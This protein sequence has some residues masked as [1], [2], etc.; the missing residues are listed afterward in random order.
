VEQL[1]SSVRLPPRRSELSASLIGLPS[2]VPELLAAREKD[3]KNDF[4]IGRELRLSFGEAD[5]QSAALSGR[6][7]ASGIGKGTRVGLLFPNDSAWVVAWLAVARVGALAVP[8]STFSPAP[9]LATAIRHADVHAVL[10]AARFGH[11][12]LIARLEEGAAGLANSP[13]RLALP[14]LPLLRWIHVHDDSPPHWSCALA[15]PLGDELVRGAQQT[16]VAPD[17]LVIVSTSGATAAPK[18]VVHT[19]GSLVRHGALL[20]RHRGL[21][22]EDRI[23]SPMPFFWVG[24]LTMV[25]LAAL[26]SGAAA[27][28]QE[29]FDAG[30]ALLLAERE[31]VTQISCWPNAARSMA[32]HPTFA[33]RDLSS[34]RGGTLVEAL[35]VGQ[36]PPSPDR[37]PVPLGMTE[38]GGPHTAVADPY[39]PLPEEL[40]GTCGTALAGIEH[41][42]VDVETGMELDT[43]SGA[44]GEILVRGPFLMDNLYKRERHETFSPDGWYATGDMGWFDADGNLHFTGRRTAMIKSGGANISPAE[45][46]DALTQLD[47]VRAAFVFGVPAGERGEDVAAVVALAPGATIDLDVLVAGARRLLSSF[48]VPRQF[49]V[50]E[51]SDLPVMPTGKVDVG[52]LRSLFVAVER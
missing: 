41:L 46:E 37:A 6:L 35:P 17:P 42:V 8:L 44:E 52:A 29:R 22:S 27:V 5:A 50:I 15:D 45:V 21:T 33:E 24:G 14:D 28:V 34:V 25:L 48:K 13:P 49:R 31:R 4:L 43:G 20:A 2:T 11:H 19:H 32:E 47:G 51:E 38:T 9:E 18:A 36:R 7:L 23:Y 10:T 16:V 3:G 39:T 1:R 26:S 30:E 40:R 12:D